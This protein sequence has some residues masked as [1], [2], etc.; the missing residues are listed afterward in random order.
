[1]AVTVPSMPE[2]GPGTTVYGSS[3]GDHRDDL[4]LRFAENLRTAEHTR[5]PLPKLTSGHGDLKLDEAYEVQAINIRRRMA[6]GA[7]LVGHKVGL[8]SLAMQQQMG[9]SE[10]DSGVI[11]D[12][13]VIPDGGELSRTDLMQPRVETEIAFRLGQDVEGPDPEPESIRS[14]VSEVCIAMEIIDTRFEGWRIALVDSVAD[15]ASSAKVVLGQAIAY[16]P[17]M[18]LS[19]EVLTLHADGVTKASGEGRA[20]LGDPL[21]P[22]IWLATRLSA[23]GSSLRAGDLV[24]AGAVHASVTLEAGLDLRASSPNLPPTRLRVV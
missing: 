2:P 14:A 12:D 5:V 11:L 24:L 22:V 9:V 1:M 20:V 21:N 7:R 17:E 15:N 13:M 23:L 10:P 18:D 19:G 16:T 8:T 3:A 4:L 6:E